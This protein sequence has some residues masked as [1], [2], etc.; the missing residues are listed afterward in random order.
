M[1]YNCGEDSAY[2]QSVPLTRALPVQ[3]AEMTFRIESHSMDENMP[4]LVATY[5]R[6]DERGLETL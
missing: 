3:F 2:D 1:E 4:L 6:P 5:K